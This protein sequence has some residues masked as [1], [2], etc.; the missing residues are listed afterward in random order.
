MVNS[1]K[2]FQR[3]KLL[4]FQWATYGFDEWVFVDILIV[5]MCISILSDNQSQFKKLPL[6]KPHHINRLNND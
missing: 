1:N 5:K 3:N 2:T 4:K 6:S